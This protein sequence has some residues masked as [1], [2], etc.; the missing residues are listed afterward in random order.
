MY[1]DNAMYRT[2]LA[3][4]KLARGGSHFLKVCSGGW[5]FRVGN[6]DL[7]GDDRFGTFHFRVRKKPHFSCQRWR[8]VGRIV[9][10]LRPQ[11]IRLCVTEVAFTF[12]LVCER[13]RWRNE[14]GSS[15]TTLVPKIWQ[16]Y[17]RKILFCRK[18]FMKAQVLG[19][20]WKAN[21]AKRFSFFS[22]FFP[23]KR[24]QNYLNIC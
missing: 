14:S 23:F 22:F 20:V 15:L 7:G 18:S 21:V 12:T 8:D 24:K 11:K 1:V 17:L 6:R 16:S 13:K 4:Q 9:R 10:G 5:T 19:P 2:D 3:R